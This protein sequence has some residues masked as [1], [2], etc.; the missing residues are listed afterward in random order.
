MKKIDGRSK[1]AR[2]AKVEASGFT[3][4]ARNPVL[5]ASAA[6]VRAVNKYDRDHVWRIGDTC[7]WVPTVKQ[8]MVL[9]PPETA[10]QFL[11]SADAIMTE[12]GKNYD[13]P[14]GE[15]S[16]GKTVAVFNIITG[17]NLTEAEGWLFMQ[18]LKDVRQWTAPT[19]HQDS[20][21]DSVAYS[22]LKAEALAG[23]GV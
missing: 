9:G 23:E 19:Y 15:R 13:N 5:L 6:M 21:E 4:D 16:M 8:D 7:Y 12:R 20:A 22:A 1:A 14:Q 10:S 18:G 11:R 3:Y 2:A 17:H